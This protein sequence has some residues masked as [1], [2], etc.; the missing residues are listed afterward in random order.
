M[1]QECTSWTEL[2][3]GDNPTALDY[4]HSQSDMLMKNDGTYVLWPSSVVLAA[5]SGYTA[6]LIPEPQIDG[7]EVAGAPPKK[8][9]C[10]GRDA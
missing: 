9:R 8:R 7:S 3:A 5:L 4:I 10:L 2:Y 6:P 1:N